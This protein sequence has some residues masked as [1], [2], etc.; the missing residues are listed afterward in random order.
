MT[1]EYATKK[2]IGRKRIGELELEIE[3]LKIEIS[4]QEKIIK[5]IPNILKAYAEL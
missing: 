4:K 1:I 2:S 3:M 5:N